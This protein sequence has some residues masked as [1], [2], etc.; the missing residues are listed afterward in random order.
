MTFEEFVAKKGDAMDELVNAAERLRDM[1]RNWSDLEPE[2]KVK[3]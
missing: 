1:F 3:R 2:D